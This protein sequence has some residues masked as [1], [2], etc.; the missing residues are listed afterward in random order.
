MEDK[1]DRLS[2]EVEGGPALFLSGPGQFL[3]TAVAE[4]L[5]KEPHFNLIFGDSVDDYDREDY[6]MRELPALRVYNFTSTKLQE[7]H[8]ITG[9]LFADVIW[10]PSIRRNETEKF[11]SQVGTALLQQFRRQ[12]FFAAMRLAVPG[13]NELGKVFTV[14][15]SMSF[16]NELMGEEECPVTHITINFRLD[17]KE[18]DAYLEM[19]GRTKE[20]PFDITL[21]NLR[22]IASTIQA[23]KTESGV[24]T[25]ELEIESTQKV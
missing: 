24:N 22:V 6:S 19:Q 25:V 1:L 18:W 8:Y 14:D 11:I 16:Q 20:D 10:P 23:I 21:E 13:L 2:P 12:P 7:S 15:K 9:E 3:A 17:L 4:A 5:K